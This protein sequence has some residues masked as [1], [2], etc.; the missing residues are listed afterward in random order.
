MIE[1]CRRRFIPDMLFISSALVLA[2][3][4]W[5]IYQYINYN[6]NSGLISIDGI[7]TLPLQGFI[8][9]KENHLFIVRD[10][11]GVFAMSDIC[12]H[13]GC[14]L[15]YKDSLIECICHSGFFSRNGMPL[16]EPITDPLQRY[17]IYKAGS[18]AYIVDMTKNVDTTYRID[19]LIQK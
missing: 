7:D 11:K 1:K 13:R 5:I 10:H 9:K 8:H 14:N 16:N 2:L 6:A 12:T 17:Y 19:Y 15:L 18:N 4:V 3:F